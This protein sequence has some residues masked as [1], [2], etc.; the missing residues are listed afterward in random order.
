M[1]NALARKA[2]G[3]IGPETLTVGL[4]ALM[5]AL[6]VINPGRVVLTMGALAVLAAAVP[7]FRGTDR[8]GGMADLAQVGSRPPANQLEVIGDSLGR[9]L[10]KTTADV[11]DDLEQIQRLVA[12]AVRSLEGSFADLH[13]DN[14]TQRELFDGML[15]A[16]GNG[17]GSEDPD[18]EAVTINSFVQS[19]ADLVSYFV[20]VTTVTNEQ[21]GDLVKMID[22]MG[23]QMD[24]MVD[25]LGNIRKLADQT[26]LLSLNATIEAAR[27][28]DAGRGFAVVASE[29]RTLAQSS[30]DFNEQIQERLQGMKDSM[31]RTRNLVHDTAS[32]DADALFRGQ[33]DFEAMS[34]HV[35]RLERVLS[36][37]AQEAAQVSDRVGRSTADAIRCLQ[38][39]DIVRQVADHADHRAEQ[40]SDFFE[41][42]PRQF[43]MAGTEGL[44]RASQQITEAA[45]ELAVSAPA[46]P[47]NQDTLETG[48]IDLF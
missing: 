10:P 17:L 29:V 25:M 2:S 38:F 27:A 23:D 18:D 37:A 48:S 4:A 41:E 16:L 7:T 12:D 19:T 31:Q 34:G 47:A 24:R 14:T 42:L 1:L 36:D 5:V 3:R 6:A 43:E 33:V 26:N 30:N 46:R 35:E 39:E 45:E 28:G 40:L 13:A 8:S 22:E 9:N 21:S 11:R 44:S 15:T 20:E 32:R